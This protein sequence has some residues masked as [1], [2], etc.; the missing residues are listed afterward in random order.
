MIISSNNLVKS[1][2]FASNSNDWLRFVCSTPTNAPSTNALGMHNWWNSKCIRRRP[3]RVRNP[4]HSSFFLHQKMN[5][6]FLTKREETH[7]NL[8]DS[9]SNERMNE[10]NTNHYNPRVEEMIFCI[11][12]C[13]VVHTTVGCKLVAHHNKMHILCKNRSVGSKL[14]TYIFVPFSFRPEYKYPRFCI[15]CIEHVWFMWVIW[16]TGNVSPLRTMSGSVLI[17][18]LRTGELSLL[19]PKLHKW[20]CVSRFSIRYL[21]R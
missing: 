4:L 10:W 20:L 5:R 11:T 2:K 9:Y 7:R 3:L 19:L 17:R 1:I 12:R 15:W 21:W 18:F 14:A 6:L 13:R 8:C 16:I